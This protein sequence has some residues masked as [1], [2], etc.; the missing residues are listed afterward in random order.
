MEAIPVSFV[1]YFSCK[2]TEFGFM[3]LTGLLADQ[4]SQLLV[5]LFKALLIIFA[6]VVNKHV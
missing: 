5:L 4:D 6:S 1:K 3:W 2:L